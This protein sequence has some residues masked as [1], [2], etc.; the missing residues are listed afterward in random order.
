MHY[1]QHLALETIPRNYLSIVYDKMGN[2]KAS[3][4][5][6]HKKAKDISNAMNL[7]ISLT[8]T[9][10]HGHNSRGF[11]NFSLSFLDMGSNFTITSFCKCIRDIEEQIVDIYGDLLYSSGGLKHTLHESLLQC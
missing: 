7:P 8:R 1:A 11:G 3:I 4:P 2:P 5:R 6:L 10:T 9:L